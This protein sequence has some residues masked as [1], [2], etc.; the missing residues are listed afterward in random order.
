MIL[1]RKSF[2]TEQYRQPMKQSEK[3]V[4]SEL[5]VVWL[6]MEPIIICKPHM[7]VFIF[8]AVLKLK[9]KNGLTQAGLVSIP[10]RSHQVV[11]HSI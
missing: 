2:D 10:N 5:L 6:Y 9:V 3:Q 1:L 11:G 8:I 7:F 4:S